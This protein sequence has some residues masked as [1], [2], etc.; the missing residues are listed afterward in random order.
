MLIQKERLV[1]MLRLVLSQRLGQGCA[2][3]EPRFSARIDAAAGAYDALHAL[4]LEL[5]DPPLRPDWPYVEPLEWEGIVAE[6]HSLR[7]HQAWPRPDMSRAAA[8]AEAGFLGS[9]CGCVLGKPVEIDPT[10]AELKQAAGGEQRWPLDDYVSE[11]FLARLGRRHDSW[12]E[13]VRERISAV[14]ADDDLHYSILG[15]LV[16]ERH[17]LDFGTTE[18]FRL[19]SENVPS[20]WTW[21]PERTALLSV[22]AHQHH[23]FAAAAVEDSHDVLFLNPGDEMCG[24]LIRADAYGY[25]CPGNPD[26]AAWLA[27]K[28]ASFTHVRT[29]VYGPMF[30]A[31][32]LANCHASEAGQAGNHRLE[33]VTSALDRVPSKSRFH[34]VVADS[35]ERVAAATD[36]ESAYAEVHRRYSDYTHCQ[37]YQ[38][39]GTLVNTIRFAENVG[40]GIGLQ[41]SQGNDT[42]SFG[43]TAGSVLGVLFGPGHLES[44]WLAPFDDTIAHALADFHEY[45]LSAVAERM[46]R[47]PDRVYAEACQK[48][49]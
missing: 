38:E 17:G 31:A 10:L 29:G 43:A 2:I 7:P 37:V 48:S 35:V 14:A 1:E 6:S 25:A 47:L 28:D 18:L 9:V 22:A 45:S 19:W 3:D 32:L 42:D 13:T 4:A 34:E 39:I 24:A 26:L 11:A 49:G 46:S 27:W 8:R 30:I 12:A 36:W 40:H 33:L 21:G 23:L 44:R 20:G 15:M 41:V 5:R 16:L